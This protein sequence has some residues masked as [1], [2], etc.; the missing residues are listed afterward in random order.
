MSVFRPLYRLFNSF[1]S[2]LALRIANELEYREAKYIQ[3]ST[4]QIE[5]AMSDLEVKLLQVEQKIEAAIAVA[6]AHFQQGLASLKQQLTE[7]ASRDTLLGVIGKL[8]ADAVSIANLGSTADTLP[9][10]TPKPDGDT[11][12]PADDTLKTAEA[13]GEPSTPV[14]GNELTSSDTANESA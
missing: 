4:Q 8:E 10:V 13:T 6:S 1:V 11:L 5:R 9:L 7:G 3:Q 12:P 2:A 14:E